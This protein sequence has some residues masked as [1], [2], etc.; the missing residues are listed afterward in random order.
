MWK[1]LFSVYVPH[2][3]KADTS[4]LGADLRLCPLLVTSYPLLV[5]Y[6]A[7]PNHFSLLTCIWGDNR[8]PENLFWEWMNLAI[9]QRPS[10]KVQ[11]LHGMLFYSF[12][13]FAMN[14]SFVQ[15]YTIEC[16]LHSNM[17]GNMETIL[18]IWVGLE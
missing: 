2:P 4:H 5:A 14:A 17:L 10:S 18:W 8:S 7:I 11:W 6:Q 9:A 12:P 3:N 13:T 1:A 16:C 15:I